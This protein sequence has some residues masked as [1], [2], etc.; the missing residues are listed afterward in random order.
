M[1]I[2][3]IIAELLLRLSALRNNNDNDN[4]HKLNLPPQV[5][6]DRNIR[7]MAI[8]AEWLWPP[9]QHSANNMKYYYILL[10]YI[11]YGKG[12]R[13]KENV[14][15]R[16]DGMHALLDGWSERGSEKMCK[17]KKV[18]CKFIQHE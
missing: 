11:T 17:W 16:V 5:V 12:D 15:M 2:L 14:A 1:I 13:Q 9:T 4:S 3:S 10:T 18:S 6:R 7:S 8:T